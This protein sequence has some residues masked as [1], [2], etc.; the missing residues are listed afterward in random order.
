MVLSLY[1]DGQTV[2][3]R[4]QHAWRYLT[5]FL[6]ASASGSTLLI[7]TD[8]IGAVTC[9]RLLANV[10]FDADTIRVRIPR[11]CLDRPRWVKMG[12]T[13]LG[14]DFTTDDA[15]PL[16][17]FG[18]AVSPRLCRATLTRRARRARSDPRSRSGPA[19]PA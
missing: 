17:R 15:L 12:I 11:L 18:N 13:S 19:A 4:G 8:S 16:G 6:S 2:R 1:K 5:V 9:E 7:D 3:D 10:D 14:T